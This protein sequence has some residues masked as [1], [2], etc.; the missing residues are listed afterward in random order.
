MSIGGVLTAPFVGRLAHKFS[1]WSGILLGI[2]IYS[3]GNSIFTAAAGLSIGAILVVI[4][5]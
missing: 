4:L 2:M 1:A 5:S 3:I